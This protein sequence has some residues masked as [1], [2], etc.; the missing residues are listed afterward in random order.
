NGC[1]A[2]RLAALRRDWVL[3]DPPGRFGRARGDPDGEPDPHKGEEDTSESHGLAPGPTPPARYAGAL[4]TWRGPC[5]MIVDH[6]GNQPTLSVRRGPP[7]FPA[8]VTASPLFLGPPWTWPT[9]VD[10]MRR[11]PDAP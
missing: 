11:L 7:A 2:L 3:G 6:P 9:S 8:G 10:T 1:V 5:N 4:H